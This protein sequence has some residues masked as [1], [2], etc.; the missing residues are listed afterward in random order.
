MRYR[1]ASLLVCT[2]L[3]TACA[4]AP[5]PP[6]APAA[7]P[8]NV[9]QWLAGQSRAKK[10]AI[11]GALIGGLLGGVSA[12]LAGMSH[13]EIANR[14]VAGAIAGA[15]AGY[16][17]GKHQDQIFAGRDLAVRRAGYHSSG[18]HSSDGYVARIEEVVFDPANPKPGQTASLYV[19]YLVLGPDP[20]ESI[21]VQ[22]F[23]GLKYGDDYVFG[24]GPNEFVVPKGGGVVESTM[25]VTLPKKAIIGTYTVE[26]LLEDAD[27][28]FPQASGTGAVYIA[29][30]ARPRGG[31]VTAAR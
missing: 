30:A 28:R 1:I 6:A 4:T 17:I 26:A 22:M 18:Y 20:N 7:K 12:S 5:A 14:V 8:S 10:K 19:R 29:V 13:E 3:F 25:Q 16:A 15:T 23:R 9:K 2:L 31:A 24:A 27:G 11:A 21:K